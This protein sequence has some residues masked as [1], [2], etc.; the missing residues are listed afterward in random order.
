MTILPTSCG[1]MFL[2]G[3][4]LFPGTQLPL[5]IFEDRY[6]QMLADALEGSRMFTIAMKPPQDMP[7]A[8]LGLVTT[9][10]E[11]EDGTSNLMLLGIHRVRLL[12]ILQETP[13]Q[14]HAIEIV[15]TINDLKEAEEPVFQE[16]LEIC[17]AR[18]SEEQNPVLEMLRS[19]ETLEQLTDHISA[20]FIDSAEDRNQLMQTMSLQIRIDEL[21]K[22]ISH[23]E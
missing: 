9:C 4:T 18:I 17:E 13:F 16:L 5:R 15:D 7:V 20:L 22:L 6:R 19:Q 12:N 14:A 21:R 1:V 23:P 8:G 11:Q 3:V 2:S 10:V